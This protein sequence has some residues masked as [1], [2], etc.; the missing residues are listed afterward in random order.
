M[1]VLQI[2]V[3]ALEIWK[4]WKPVEESEPKGNIVKIGKNIWKIPGNL[5]RLAVIQTPVKNHQLK[6]V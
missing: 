1:T 4:N 2:V 5:R 3:G 6:L